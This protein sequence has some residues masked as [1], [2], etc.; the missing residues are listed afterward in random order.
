[1]HGS[2][3]KMTGQG[4]D[5]GLAGMPKTS[6]AVAPMEA[7]NPRF[8]RVAFHQRL[9]SVVS[10]R[11]RAMRRASLALV[12]TGGAGRKWRSHCNAES[13]WPGT[14]GA[15]AGKGFAGA[16]VAEAGGIAGVVGTAGEKRGA[17]FQAWSGPRR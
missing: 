9:I 12:P 10:S 13:G 16:L 7:M 1:M 8:M 14:D 3:P 5:T 17:V 15:L 4:W 11:P 6:T 2:E